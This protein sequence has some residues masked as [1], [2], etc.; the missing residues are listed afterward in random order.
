MMRFL[1]MAI[2]FF[3]RVIDMLRGVDR[4]K[5]GRVTPGE[6]GATIADLNR[7]GKV[8]A[9]DLA[10]FLTAAAPVAGALGYP[11]AAALIADAARHLMDPKSAPDLGDL[12]GEERWTVSEPLAPL[13]ELQRS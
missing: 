7:D 13:P 10:I 2:R 3:P 8:D 4:N 5:D 11:A 12:R 1:T 6:V 9:T